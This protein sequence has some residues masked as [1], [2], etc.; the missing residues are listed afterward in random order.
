MKSQVAW[1]LLF[2]ELGFRFRWA[3]GQ[4]FF[5]DSFAAQLQLTSI[6]YDIIFHYYYAISLNYMINMSER[7]SIYLPRQRR[8]H[9][10]ALF[11]NY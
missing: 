7:E 9:D 11:S 5:R 3:F 6:D 2:G 8:F 10:F 1:A 4:Y